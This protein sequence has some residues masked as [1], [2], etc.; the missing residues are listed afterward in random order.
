M[1]QEISTS[2]IIQTANAP[3]RVVNRTI[4]RISILS[5]V[6]A[7]AFLGLAWGAALRAWMALLALEFGDRPVFT[8][9]GTFGAILLPAALMGALLGGGACAAETSDGKGWR[10]VILSPVLLIIGPAIATDDFIT[11]LLTTGVGGG[12]IGVALLGLLGGYALS[13]FGAIWLRWG[14]GLLAL[15]LTFA[16]GIGVFY[17]NPD[18]YALPGASKPFGALFFILL[19]ALLVAG[20]SAPSRYPSKQPLSG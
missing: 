1:S 2:S 9:Q 13:G 5:R 16:A 10:W 15:L 6:V 7:G 11:T 3:T 8:W 18:A 17:G 12:A 20:V 4:S 19:M 14:S